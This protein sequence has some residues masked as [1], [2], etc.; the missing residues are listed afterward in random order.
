MQPLRQLLIDTDLALLR[1]IA[2]RW[3]IELQAPSKA[4]DIATVIAG[5]FSEPEHAALIIK[6]LTQ[7]ERDTLRA[8]IINGL[9]MGASGFAQRFGSIR[10]VGP[11][12]LERD[13]PWR[14]PIS[15]AEGLWYLGL[16][17]R[18][19]EQTPNGMQEVI[20]VPE[21]LHPLSSLLTARELPEHTL[22]PLAAPDTSL[23]SHA[24]FADDLCTLLAHH[25]NQGDLP[26]SQQL[27]DPNPERST[28]LKHLAHRA[29]LIQHEPGKLDPTPVLAWLAAPTVDQLR[30]LFNAWSHDPHWNDLYHV[31][32]LQPEETGSWSN[33]PLLARQA[34]LQHLL[35]ALPR[36][37]H[38]IDALI[39][40]V[41][42]H[43]PDFAR[44]NFDTWYI[45]DRAS[46]EYLRGFEAWDK[47]EGA[48]IKY[49]LLYPLFWIGIVNLSADRNL[50]SITPLGA[51]LLGQAHASSQ[52]LEE[53]TAYY[54]I[55]ADATIRVS[56]SRRYERFQ[57]ARVANFVSADDTY[58]YRI[59][60]KSLARARAQK[61]DVSRIIESFEQASQS[62]VPPP[63]EKALRRW[64]EKGVEARIERTLL[65]QVKSEAVV[66]RLRESLKTRN[67]IGDSVGKTAIKISEK[68]W[69]RL[70][71][72]LAELGLLV[73]VD[74]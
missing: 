58:M 48:L 1:V 52:T 3:E 60:P 27:R 68:N 4:R 74:L 17:Y 34:L 10:P 71:S 45:R 2:S 24:T 5:W 57:L 13:Q 67:L 47:I 11:A 63:V 62:E 55:Y 8:L 43:T 73:D 28:F 66:Q 69:P 33:D 44:T 50:F 20:V 23:A 15:P 19:F 72:A 9:S 39:A 46:A 16:I 70:V 29:Q 65:L 41:K 53:P 30:G 38:S 49:I 31:P 21:E 40:H 18:A 37:W 42:T 56:A 35:A 7:P 64:H 22:P 6:R 54:H 32:T 26:L 51:L 61:I 36:T 14:A 59:T 12:R 25:L